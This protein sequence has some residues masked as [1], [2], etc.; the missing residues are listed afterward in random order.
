MR[1]FEPVGR[2]PDMLRNGRKFYAR[3]PLQST[4]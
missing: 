3:T 1:R 2:R 4:A